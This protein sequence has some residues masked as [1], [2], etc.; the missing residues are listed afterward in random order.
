[1]VEE[2]T[3]G[4]VK[5]EEALVDDCRMVAPD[6]ARNVVVSVHAEV[7]RGKS[8]RG[9][10]SCRLVVLVLVGARAEV[11]GNRCCLV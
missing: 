3:S 9:R 6:F 5:E 11:E 7:S 1:V 4:S 10:R 8:V 2:E